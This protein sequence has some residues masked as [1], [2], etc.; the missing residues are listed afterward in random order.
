MTA[1]ATFDHLST[2]LSLSHQGESGQMFGKQCIKV[3][4]KAAVAL[5][6]DNLVFKLPAA[7]VQQALLLEGSELWDPSGKGRTM[8]EW[9]QIPID[10]EDKFSRLATL[11]ADYVSP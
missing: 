2:N 6:K 4:G 3:G 9:V 10:H 11:A 8:K 5:F 7:E 1:Q